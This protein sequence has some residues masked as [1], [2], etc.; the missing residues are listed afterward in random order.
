MRLIIMILLATT[1]AGWIASRIELSHDVPP[2]AAP[3]IDWVRTV[4]GWER[5]SKL[6]PNE[7]Q[8]EQQYEP[9]IHPLVVASLQLILSLAALITFAPAEREPGLLRKL[10]R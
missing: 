4:D 9:P 1:L 10:L 8:Y 3:R 2:I 5:R 6:F 7:H